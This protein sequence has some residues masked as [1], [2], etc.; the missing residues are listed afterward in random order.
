MLKIKE[1]SEGFLVY[2]EIEDQEY[3]FALFYKMTWTREDGEKVW[4]AQWRAEEYMKHLE[5][6]KDE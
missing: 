4:L 3:P 6:K 1:T 2:K 5:S